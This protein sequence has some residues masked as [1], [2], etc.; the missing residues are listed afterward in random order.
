MD[1]AEELR[2]NCHPVGGNRPEWGIILQRRQTTT[3]KPK[4][5]TLSFCPKRV[6]LF[7]CSKRDIETGALNAW[8]RRLGVPRYTLDE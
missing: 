5:V 1:K 6:T 2:L 7:F 4:R 3:G 8:V